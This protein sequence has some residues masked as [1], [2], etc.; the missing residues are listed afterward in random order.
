[1]R[2]IMG[3]KWVQVL[4]GRPECIPKGR[5]R[6][7][8][9]EGVKFEDEVS[10]SAAIDADHGVWFEF[11]DAGG[12]GFAQVDFLWHLAGAVVVGEAK[13]TWRPEAYV[14]LRRLYFPLV[15]AALG[16][17][18]GG[19]VICKNLTRATPKEE[20]VWEVGEALWVAAEGRAVPTLH[21]PLVGAGR[22]PTRGRG[23]QG[24]ERW[25][26]V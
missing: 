19:V 18:V 13:L 14:Q 26:R 4:V 6:G 22:S 16:A 24:A 20:V 8:K 15:A 21:L 10:A 9:R 1:M 23:A 5:P 17:K 7:A 3:L 2:E 25:V 12:H 11:D